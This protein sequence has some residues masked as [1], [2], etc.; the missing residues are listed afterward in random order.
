MRLPLARSVI[1]EKFGFAATSC[2]RR[3]V[4]PAPEDAGYFYRPIAV[5]C[6]LDQQKAENNRLIPG[7]LRAIHL[8][9]AYSITRIV[10]RVFR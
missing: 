3:C 9:A 6:T 5:F 1:L 8:A 7:N 2:F 10:E 4:Q